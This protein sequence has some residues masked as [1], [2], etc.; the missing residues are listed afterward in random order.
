MDFANL[1]SLTIPEGEVKEIYSGDVLLWKGGYT[2]LV[3][4][5]TE[6]DDVTIYNGGLGYK[7]GERI[8]SGG[9]LGSHGG[10]SHTGFIRAVG[11]DVVRLSGYD[12]KKGDTANAINVYNASHSNLGQI[13]PNSNWSYGI[14]EGGIHNWD[15]V[16]LEKSGVYYWVVPEGFDIEYI[17]VTGY[18]NADGSKMIVTVNEEIE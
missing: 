5:S 10:A 1:K 3:P 11:G 9:A 13:T 7:N 18:T 16:I 12:I 4:L 17:R 6:A 8:R 14:F 2:N 15:D